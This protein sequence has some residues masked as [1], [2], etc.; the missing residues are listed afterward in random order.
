MFAL[1]IRNSTKKDFDQGCSIGGN[2]FNI[3]AFLRVTQWLSV[4]LNTG[5]EIPRSYGATSGRK[6]I[7]SSA[8]NNQS[9]NPPSILQPI[10]DLIP[11]KP[12]NDDDDYNEDEDEE[13]EEEVERDGGEEREG[14]EEMVGMGTGQEAEG[15]LSQTLTSPID[16]QIDIGKKEN[17]FRPTN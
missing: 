2:S 4:F 8:E 6:A 7:V 1:L 11:I 14:A 3:G 17:H 16:A 15:N 5:R 12:K 13:E 10:L 9:I